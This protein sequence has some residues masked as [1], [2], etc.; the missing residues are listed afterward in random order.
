M[1][2]DAWIRISTANDEFF[3][4]RIE[5]GTYANEQCLKILRRWRREDVESADCVF[6]IGTTG[7]HV[8]PGLWNILPLQHA[9]FV[10]QIVQTTIDQ[11]KYRKRVI[12]RRKVYLL[13]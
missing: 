8:L 7:H 11:G 9:Y 10:E 6:Q 1:A 2:Y 12:L 5:I 4:A 13:A 3:L